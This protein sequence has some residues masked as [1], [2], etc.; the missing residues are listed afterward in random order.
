MAGVAPRL[1]SPLFLMVLVAFTAGAAPTLSVEDPWVKEGPP[2]ARVLAGYM[3]IRNGSSQTQTIIGVSS[4][5][6]AM[7]EMHRTE[8]QDGMARMVEQERL[9][10]PASGQLSLEPGGYHLMLMGANR[11]LREGDTVEISLQPENGEAVVI[12][13]PVRKATLGTHHHH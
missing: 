13:A 2:S 3:T 1:I 11:P 5:A 9:K 12:Q 7:V 4:P 10:V 8:I 6:F